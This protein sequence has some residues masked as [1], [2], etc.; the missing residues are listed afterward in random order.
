MF[1]GLF[2]AIVTPF[3]K[4][5][6]D[7]SAYRKLINYV[8]EGGADG[9]VPNGTTGENPTLDD[10]ERRRI[11]SIAVEICHPRGAK[12]IAGAGTYNTAHSIELMNDV[13]KLGADAGLVI[14][15]YY[16]KPT[17][18]GLLLHFRHIAR[19]TSLPMV[20]YNVP[21]RT[22]VNMTADTA[23][24]LSQEKNIVAL[25]E[26][27]GSLT[28]ISDIIRRA[29]PDFDV[30]SGDDALTL[31]IMSIGGKGVISVAGNIAP[32]LMKEMLTA[33][34]KRNVKTALKLHWK[35]TPLF[36]A[37]FRETSP[38]PCKQALEFL[39][40]CSAEVRAPLSPV[41]K[42]TTEALKKALHALN[43]NV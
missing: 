28:Q 18:D 8:L 12:V 23:V 1:T 38:S 41:R 9:I 10:K 26:A 27:S 14:T 32:K 16:N 34:D 13:E 20:M 35:L 6:L 2:V 42:E 30:L 29:N 19:A 11:I 36:E 37:L 7:E 33:W 17:Q 24:E 31:P 5:K 22:G 43:F 21:S 40:I 3:K 39:G 25:K 15:P 4:G